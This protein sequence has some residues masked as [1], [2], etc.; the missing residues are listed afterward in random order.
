MRLVVAPEAFDDL[1][2]AAGYIAQHNPSA[3][4][5]LVDRVLEVLDLLAEGALDGP[6]RTLSSGL[7][8]RSWPVPPLRI[9][10]RREP[11]ALVV[12]RIYHQA[13]RP[14]DS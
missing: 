9:F 7:E 8:V 5:R 2:S 11:D 3:A 12:L 13:R 4:A 6:R 1:A 10:Y 14:L